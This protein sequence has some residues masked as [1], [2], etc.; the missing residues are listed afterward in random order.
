MQ[1]PPRTEAPSPKVA[2]ELCSLLLELAG[3]SAGRMGSARRHVGVLDAAMPYMSKAQRGEAR[4]RI[5]E[6]ETK[7]GPMLPGVPDK[8]ETGTIPPETRAARW[9]STRKVPERHLRVLHRAAAK[10][11]EGETSLSNI[12]DHAFAREIDYVLTPVGFDSFK[13]WLIELRIARRLAK[14]VYGPGL[15]LRWWLD[16]MAPSKDKGS[17][18]QACLAAAW[19]MRRQS[20]AE[21][22][23]I[24]V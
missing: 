22:A 8:Q 21:K 1:A 23:I 19:E 7:W 16:Q 10:I 11:A 18:Y 2:E 13:E 4:R 3:R 15:L 14:G 12:M 24:S 20:L 17:T 6:L 9:L 5:L